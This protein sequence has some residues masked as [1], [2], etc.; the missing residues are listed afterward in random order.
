MPAF[1]NYGFQTYPSYYPTFQAPAVQSMQP[2][3]PAVQQTM[4]PQAQVGNVWVH[5]RTEVDVY[6]V[7]PNSAVRLWDV[8]EPVFYLKQADA[9]GR[10]SV[11]TF[12]IVKRSEAP[13]GAV[14]EHREIPEYATKADLEAFN[15]A[16]DAVK[17]DVAG[18]L[19]KM[20]GKA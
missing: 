14:S 16:L 12:D 13:Q 20:E 11:E 17:K 10:P 6:P 18:L 1:P 4:T 19:E 9:S 3:I 7:A 8:N 2:Q 5:N 15:S